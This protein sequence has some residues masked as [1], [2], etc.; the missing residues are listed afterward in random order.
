[1]ITNERND[2]IVRYLSLAEAIAKKRSSVAPRWIPLSD[3]ISAAYFGLIDAANKFD[4]RKGS[5]VTYAFWRITGEVMSYIR[6]E[7]RARKHISID[8]PDE[9]GVCIRDIIPDHRHDNFDGL[10]EKLNPIGK[11]L[12]VWYYIDRMTMREIAERIGVKQP[13]V[14]KLLNYYTIQLAA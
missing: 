7:I 9:N 6:S 3:L 12:M 10:I 8:I 14:S 4:A 13:R 1:M 5:F 2:L 11:K